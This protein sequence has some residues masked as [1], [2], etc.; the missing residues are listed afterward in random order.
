MPAKPRNGFT[1]VETLVAIGVLGMFFSAI[2]V[3]LRDV[4]TNIAEARI[5]SVALTIAQTKLETIKNL[6]Y[7][8]V[9]TSG[10]I[11]SG[12]IPQSQNQEVGGQ[13]YTVKTSI[14]YIDDPFDGEVP[15]DTI[16]ADYKRVRVEVSWEGSNP[17]RFPVA[18]VTNIVPR[19][20]E[21]ITGG[22]TLMIR[23]FDSQGIPVGNAT[24]TVSNTSVSP[25]IN[26][27]TLSSSSG[28][29]AIPG[30]PACITCYKISATKSGYS[31]DKTYTPGVAPDPINRPSII[32]TN[33]ISPDVTVIEGQ[34]TQVSFAIDKVSAIRFF[35][36]GTA[37]SGYPP[38]GNVSFTLRGS[39]Q[40]GTT[41]SDAP[42]YKFEQT[43]STI[44]FTYYL[45]NLEWDTYGVDFTGRGYDLAGSNPESPI[46]V[47]PGTDT[48][49]SLSLSVA[50]NP[51]LLVKIKESPT[52]MSASASA[53]LAN[54]AQTYIA[55][56]STS[57]TGSADYG[58]IYFS[59]FTPGTYT[60]K[61]NANGFQEASSSV[62]LTGTKTETITLNPL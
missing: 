29:V 10:G 30:A 11:P 49:E 46:L 52:V 48:T 6:P 38:I 23:V 59:G 35:T 41:S 20:I 45:N 24:V 51:S 37:E 34:V 36:Y 43:V 21:S 12:T 16:S 26:L 62:S 2:V 18:L 57:A 5:R 1:L 32:L 9:G 27:N 4:F 15:A 42:V 25:P 28:I 40:L 31:T 19:G 22:G 33:P 47:N 56:K 14:F 58:H 3:I 60:L 53:E 13:T 54:F 17:S 7:A 39:K 8:S 50:N 44:G 61:I 55:T